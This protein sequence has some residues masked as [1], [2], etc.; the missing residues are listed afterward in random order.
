[1]LPALIGAARTASNVKSATK[2][3]P[4]RTDRKKGGA[5][6][7]QERPTMSG[8]V[9]GVETRRARVETK[10][11]IVPAL[12]ETPKADPSKPKSRSISKKIDLLLK[13]TRERNKIDKD[14]RKKEKKE[15]ETEKRQKKEEEKENLVK[16]L[17]LGIRDRVVAPVKS[18][19]DNILNA[20]KTIIVAKIAM[21]VVDNPEIFLS[22][23]KGIARIVDVASS[24]IVTTIDILAGV[25]E[26]GYKIADGFNEWKDGSLTGKFKEQLDAL[27]PAINGFL[28]AALVVGGVLLANSLRDLGEKDIDLPEQEKQRLK[29]EAERVKKSKTLSGRTPADR[30]IKTGSSPIQKTKIGSPERKLARKVQIK[31]GHAAREIFEAKYDDLRSQGKSAFEANKGADNAVKRAL[32]RKPSLSK[33]QLGTLSARANRIRGTVGGPAAKNLIGSKIFGRGVDKATQRFF[34]KVIGKGGVQ[35]LKKIMGKI[36]VIGPL[37]VFGL[38]WASG[39]SIL[40]SGA[41]AV[42]SGLG[43][44]IGT[45]AGGALGAAGGPLAPITVPLGAF[46]GN[47]LGSMGGE[48]LG[49]FFY[50]VLSGKMGKSPGA[51]GKTVGKAIEKFFKQDWG[52]IGKG[53]V[54]WLL[55]TMRDIGNGAWNIISSMVKFM[56]GVDFIKAIGKAFNDL[57][58]AMGV[59]IEKLKKFDLMGAAQAFASVVGQLSK[60]FISPGPYAFIWENAIKPFFKNVSKLWNNR[61]KFWDFLTREGTFQEVTGAIKGAATGAGQAVA[62]MTAATT[63][64]GVTP[65]PSGPGSGAPVVGAGNLNVSNVKTTYYDP[66]LGGINASGYKTAEGLP[67]T[68][69]G[70]G[71]RPEVF[72]AA[73]FPPLLA[74]LPS[75][76]TV[77]ARNF[78][79][80][81]TLKRPFNIIVTNSKGKR[82]VVR[83][84]DVGPGVKGHSSNHMLDFSVAAKNYLGTG[85]GF[86]IQMASSGSTPGP[87]TGT[88][89][90]TPAAPAPAPSTSE[91]EYRPTPS[92]AMTAPAAPRVASAAQ[93]ISGSPSSGVGGPPTVG[94][95]GV[96]PLPI[97]LQSVGTPPTGGMSV[98][99]TGGASLNSFYKSQL[100]GFLYKQG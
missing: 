6:V 98:V 89:P 14:Q 33:P 21:W 26:F 48:F 12:G 53:F 81:R 95:Q 42:G 76:M 11:P 32:K 86:K 28:N 69:T 88:A 54:D 1:M 55:K 78:P 71:Y 5:L 79:G 87:L 67:A 96:I 44:M 17:G 91:P 35:G 58:Y 60:L 66:A 62:G 16:K 27:L 31:H 94:Q 70:E 18:V 38:N 8:F 84:N 2:L 93:T 36:P 4:G 47:M 3:L 9:K 82:A 63:G 92:P 59:G 13:Y 73:A 46:L 80:G 34:L 10:P 57:K 64:G 77:P 20:I 30:K 41:M 40:R 97:P 56:G 45:W 68:S 43:Q 24:I 72:S 74:L 85:E 75:S 15:T 50:D 83:V 100:F 52:K 7:R 37:L 29:Q 49:G 19:F 90:P 23:Y 22:I 65:T 61:D 39:D 25:I 99:N 51:V